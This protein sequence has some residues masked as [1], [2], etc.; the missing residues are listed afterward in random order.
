MKRFCW[1]AICFL[2]GARELTRSTHFMLITANL[3]KL[4]GGG[5]F[6]LHS[7]RITSPG[8]GASQE[9]LKCDSRAGSHRRLNFC[10]YLFTR[11]AD[12]LCA[13]RPHL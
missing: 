12:L 9:E 13:I 3:L 10:G 8:T 4:A 1:R 6:S 7:S 5:S 2:A 11:P